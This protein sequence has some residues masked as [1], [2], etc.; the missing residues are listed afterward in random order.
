MLE[1]D[2][3]D[4]DD[5]DKVRISVATTLRKDIVREGEDEGDVEEEVESD[6]FVD[7]V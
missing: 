2:I 6:F 3:E 7:D 4:E 1:T 5:D